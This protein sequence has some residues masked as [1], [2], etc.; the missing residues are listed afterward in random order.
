MSN[1][2]ETARFEI[3]VDQID[4]PEIGLLLGKGEYPGF[5][6]FIHLMIRG[7]PLKQI[8]RTCITISEEDLV[9][10]G[11]AGDLIGADIKIDKHLASGNIRRV[12]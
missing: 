1:S 3:L 4:F 7:A 2:R 8:S 5:V 10:A 9:A 12:A 11:I 6:D